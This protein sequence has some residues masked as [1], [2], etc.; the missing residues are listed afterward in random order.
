MKRIAQ[1]TEIFCGFQL[2]AMRLPSAPTFR[3]AIMTRRIFKIFALLWAS[4]VVAS[5]GFQA[6]ATDPIPAHDTFNVAS[7]TL[8]EKRVINIYL[9]DGYSDTEQAYPVVY[10]PDGGI[11]EDFPH[12]ANTLAEMIKSGKIE[13]VILVGIENTDR[14]RDLTPS[15]TTA[16]D[17][18]YGP[19]GD[20]ATAFRTFIRDE[21]I[22]MVESKYRTA[23]GR[24]IIGESAAGLFVIDT[25]FREPTLF[26]NYIAMDPALWWDDHKLV[27]QAPRRLAASDLSG[28]TLWFAGSSAKD[29][30][31]HTRML[32]KAFRAA[33]PSG[34][35]WTYRDSPKE[36]HTTIFRATKESAFEWSLGNSLNT[37]DDAES[38]RTP[39][40]SSATSKE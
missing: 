19:A 26:D 24:T 2:F 8:N 23:Q 6:A 33:E 36:K 4:I 25:F 12:I 10:M 1:E 35:R 20:G 17:R 15:S 40:L 16:Y 9:P 31:P 34:L 27:K 7:E 30:Q 14:R 21:L 5:C 28:K 38:R 37:S 39:P 3:E 11:E 18:D 29:I 22:P 32:E 13:E